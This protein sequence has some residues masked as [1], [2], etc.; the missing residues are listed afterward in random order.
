VVKGSDTAAF[1][2]DSLAKLGLTPKEYNEFIVY[3]LPRMQNHPYNFIRFLGREYT[4]TAP[5]TITPKPDSMLRV[6]MAF[7]PLQTPIKVRMQ[8][9]QPF[10]R[11]G[12]AAV[13]WGG[14]ELRASFP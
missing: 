1:L 9:L 6:F 2:Q 14:T 13:E 12:F 10:R 8:S 3:W 4:D 7:K 5:L 11:H